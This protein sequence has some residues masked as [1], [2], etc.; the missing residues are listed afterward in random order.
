[1][2]INKEQIR[3]LLNCHKTRHYL[4]KVSRVLTILEREIGFFLRAF[5]ALHFNFIVFV[6][7][8]KFINRA[9]DIR[10]DVVS[11]V[12]MENIFGV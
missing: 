7:S 8:Q 9:D 12:L 1:M 3:E 11:L 4:I 10:S 5:S 2:Y 6:V